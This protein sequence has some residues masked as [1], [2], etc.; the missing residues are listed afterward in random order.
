MKKITVL[1]LLSMAIGFTFAQKP[2]K[3]QYEADKKKMIEAQKKLDAAKA[4]MTP[5]TRKQFDDMMEKI[6]TQTVL[7][8]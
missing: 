3:E 7:T 4:A 5:E 8:V 2:T 6:H 1:L